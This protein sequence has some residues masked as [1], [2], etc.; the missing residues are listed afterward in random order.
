MKYNNSEVQIKN[1]NDLS[2][3][4]LRWTGWL[5]KIFVGILV[6]TNYDDADDDNCEDTE[7]G[8]IKLISL[9]GSYI[10]SYLVTSM[11]PLASQD[12][13]AHH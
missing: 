12:K 10:N 6:I 11:K 13:H 3:F 9:L 2:Q 4:H 1:R 8:V 7:S 5:H